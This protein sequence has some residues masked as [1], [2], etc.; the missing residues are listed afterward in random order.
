MFEDWAGV[1]MGSSD[2]VFEKK[3][4]TGRI[5]MLVWE[6]FCED[7]LSE[8]ELLPSFMETVQRGF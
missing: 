3:L 5:E 6:N 4:L 1:F 2:W 7:R 8:A